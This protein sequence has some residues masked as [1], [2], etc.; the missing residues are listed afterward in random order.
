MFPTQKNTGGGTRNRVIILS[1]RNFKLRTQTSG[2]QAFI[3]GEFGERRPT[4]N[5]CSLCMCMSPAHWHCSFSFD[6][7]CWIRRRLFAACHSNWYSYVFVCARMRSGTL[8]ANLSTDANA[9]DNKM[10][11]LA[12]ALVLRMRTSTMRTSTCLCTAPQRSTAAAAHG[13]AVQ[14][15]LSTESYLL[16][17]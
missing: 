7:S 11:E 1:G 14:N 9:F 6:L 4:S 17:T 2:T 3:V 10:C 16:Y 8:I 13:G 15:Q 12:L 5:M